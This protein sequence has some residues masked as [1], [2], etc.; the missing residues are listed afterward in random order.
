VLSVTATWI[1]K[2]KFGIKQ[3]ATARRLGRGQ[4][5]NSD[6][7]DA[8]HDGHDVLP[9]IKHWH[10]HLNEIRRHSD[11]V[12]PRILE[13]I[14]KD[15]LLKESNR[16]D[17][18]FNI[19]ENLSRILK[20]AKQQ[21][22][23]KRK[24]MHPNILSALRSKNE[25]F[26]SQMSLDPPGLSTGSERTE[27]QHTPPPSTP[28]EPSRPSISHPS[29]TS[30]LTERR[31]VAEKRFWDCLKAKDPTAIDLFLELIYSYPDLARSS[32]HNRTPIMIAA[33]QY[34]IGM[35]LNLVHLSEL[36]H[37]D[38]EGKTLLHHMILGLNLAGKTEDVGD[39]TKAIAE[40]I[41]VN[42]GVVTISDNGG[43]TPLYFC[44]QQ[45]MLET[46]KILVPENTT[47]AI[48]LD[49]LV[50]AAKCGK[51][52]TAQPREM[53]RYLLGRMNVKDGSILS[54]QD[55]WQRLHKS[56]QNEILRHL[57]NSGPGSASTRS[58][59]NFFQRDR[60]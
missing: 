36:S 38:N 26:G 27:S 12:T 53:L 37:Q 55:K 7:S 15:M 35:V 17:T 10:N 5:T 43:R 18:C 46:A 21:F 39:F 51:L 22:E 48:D 59:L 33:Q 56:E 6:V 58:R 14:E 20:D 29:L 31:K 19:H 1:V 13:L 45:N 40:V 11:H 44:V 49:L 23:S 41:K 47:L 30:V 54:K 28:T 3:Y 24:E 42:A 8:F 32:K 34:N 52:G 9:E 4:R 16:R 57:Q 60:S 50:N 2:G 25:A